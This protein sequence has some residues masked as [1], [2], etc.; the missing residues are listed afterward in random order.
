[1]KV[2]LEGVG[3]WA[4]KKERLE[5]VAGLYG[6]KRRGARGGQGLVGAG[7]SGGI[8]VDFVTAEKRLGGGWGREMG[9]LA[10]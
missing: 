1:M 3:S 2:R 8:G 7:G 10:Y 9:W 6:D 5:G 4:A